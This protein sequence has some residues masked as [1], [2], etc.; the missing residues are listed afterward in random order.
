M[1]L[2]DTFEW[3]L[4]MGI[5][6]RDALVANG[7]HF[8]V[9]TCFVEQREPVASKTQEVSCFASMGS[10]IKAKSQKYLSGWNKLGGEGR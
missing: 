5:A 9:S 8:D 1:P 3:V 10:T 4:P 2:G 7:I 6:L